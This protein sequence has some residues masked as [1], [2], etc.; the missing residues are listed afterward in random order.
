MGLA[1]AGE[2]AAQA[3]D[4]VIDF[5]DAS[6]RLSF[7]QIPAMTYRVEW[8]TNLSSPNWS[9]SA[10]GIAAIAASGVGTLTVTVGVVH[11][12]C[13]YRVVASV[14]NEPPNGSAYA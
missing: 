6:G 1:L 12:S 14:T 8:T 11:A 2:L 3:T 4:L 10:P 13:Y 9:S 7:H 5:F